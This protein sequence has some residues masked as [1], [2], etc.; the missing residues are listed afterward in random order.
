MNFKKMHGLGNDFV[1]LDQKEIRNGMLTNAQITQ[2]CDRNRGVGC[3]LLT[4]LEPSNNADIFARFYN[5]DGSE[6]AACGNATR[7][8]AGTAI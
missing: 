4:V 7:I 6:S 8:A 5:A 1:I 2:I 3:D